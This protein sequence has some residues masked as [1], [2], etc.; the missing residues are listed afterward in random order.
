VDSI[1]TSANIEDLVS[2]GTIAARKALEIT[3][4]V[5][6]VLAIEFLVSAQAI[7][8]RLKNKLKLGMRTEKVYKEI[9]KIVPY[10]SK[11]EVYYHYINALEDLINQTRLISL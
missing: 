1:P 3:Q 11:D 8:F 4:N 7:D 6:H 5:K 10:F 2:M 9:R